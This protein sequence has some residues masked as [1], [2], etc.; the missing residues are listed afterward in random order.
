MRG[1]DYVFTR[2]NLT[3]LPTSILNLQGSVNEGQIDALLLGL[4][5][6]PQ[7]LLFN[8]PSIRRTIDAAG[9]QKLTVTYRFSH[10][11]STWNKFWNI[12][13]GEYEVIFIA[14]HGQYNNYPPSNYTGIFE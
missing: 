6:G 13:S 12:D 10:R 11:F 7:S 1:L 4:S 3:S 14:G 2:Y 5:F 8:P 9:V